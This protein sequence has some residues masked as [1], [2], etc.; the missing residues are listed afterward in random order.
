MLSRIRDMGGKGC[1]PSSTGK[2]SKVHLE[3]RVHLGAVEDR[4][5]L[6]MMRIFCW[7]KGERRMYWASFSLPGRSWLAMRT[8]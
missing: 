2:T 1:D 7:E 4:L 6:W 5:A 8:W 3:D